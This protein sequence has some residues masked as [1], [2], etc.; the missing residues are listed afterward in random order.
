MSSLYNIC[1]II[2]FLQTQQCSTKLPG[3]ARLPVLKLWQLPGKRRQGSRRL[4]GSEAAEAAT[5]RPC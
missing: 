3:R 4:C 1:Y 2:P 5:Q